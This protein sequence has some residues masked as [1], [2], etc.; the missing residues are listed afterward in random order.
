MQRS[1]SARD[2]YE[3]NKGRSNLSLLT[4]ALVSKIDLEKTASG[5]AKATGVTFIVDGATHHVK[6]NREVIV[7]GGVV[8]SPQILELSGI[9]SPKI[10]SQA[11]ID[12]AVELPAVGENLN[13]HSATLISVVSFRTGKYLCPAYLSVESERRTSYRRTASQEPRDCA[14]GYG[15]LP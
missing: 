6:A 13:E 2:Y 15:R 12:V 4:N 7:C 5:D 14:A 9:G 10:L 1:Y 3:P 11:G 8:N